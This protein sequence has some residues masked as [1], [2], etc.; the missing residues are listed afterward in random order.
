LLGPR[1]NGKKLFSD[2]GRLATL[3]VLDIIPI[4]N[5]IVLE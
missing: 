3:V 2:L 1:P 5:L 4:V